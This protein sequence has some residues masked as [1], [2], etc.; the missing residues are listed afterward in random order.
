LLACF[1]SFKA[2]STQQSSEPTTFT[3]C[4]L[5]DKEGKAKKWV[6]KLLEGGGE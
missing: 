1:L 4:Q 6:V 5:P 3:L 2:I